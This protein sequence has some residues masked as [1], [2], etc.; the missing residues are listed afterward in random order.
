MA[1]N[2]AQKES[3]RIRSD[4]S[5]S[6][7][8]KSPEIVALLEEIKDLESRSYEPKCS[9]GLKRQTATELSNSK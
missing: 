5:V 4:L 9:C 3:L 6:F 7:R 1:L 8:V 2:D